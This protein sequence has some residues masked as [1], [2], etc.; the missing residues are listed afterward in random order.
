MLFLFA[1]VMCCG[2]RFRLGRLVCREIGFEGWV[3]LEVGI[4]RWR[5]GWKGARRLGGGG[6]GEGLTSGKGS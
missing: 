5:E 4:V 6:M 1:E 2:G 3:E